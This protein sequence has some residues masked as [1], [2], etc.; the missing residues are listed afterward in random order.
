MD[1]TLLTEEDRKRWREHSIR[2]LRNYPEFGKF[3]GE[4]TYRQCGNSAATPRW[5]ADEIERLE[6]EVARLKK[7]CGGDDE[8][9][10]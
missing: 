1:C 8:E 7:L 10:R 9:K 4:E 2:F 5:A 6:A 3:N